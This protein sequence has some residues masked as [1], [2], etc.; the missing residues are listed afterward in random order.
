[1]SYTR[2]FFRRRRLST[3]RTVYSLPDTQESALR[4]KFV[5][6]YD[7]HNLSSGS[8]MMIRITA[9]VLLL[10]LP[11]LLAG[12]TR[13]NSQLRS[14][15][16]LHVTVIDATGA[17]PRPDTTVLII[18][19]R[20]AQIG[21]SE[22]L[23][24]PD[25]AHIVD[26]TGKFLIP[27]LW[28]MHVHFWYDDMLFPLYI[29]NG[30]TGVR[31][32]GSDL[33]RINHWRKEISLGSVSGPLIIAA[34]TPLD[35]LAQQSPLNE[36][37]VVNNAEEARRAVITLKNRGVDFIKVIS[38][39]S[40]QTY[41]AI[42]EEAKRQKI[43]FAGHLPEA[44]T[45]VEAS[46]AGQKSMEHM[47]GIALACSSEEVSL[48]QARAE[49]IKKQDWQTYGRIADQ[50]LDT[51][52]DEKAKAL[53]SRF[54]KNGTYQVPTLTLLKRMGY[55]YEG[56]PT[57]DL[58]LNYIPHSIKDGW[59]NPNEAKKNLSV[60]VQAFFKKEYQKLAEILL[61]M[62]RAG[63]LVM[64]GT[65]TAD[66]YTYPGFTLHDE[67]A[68]LVGAGL[69]PIETI[70][71]ATLIPAKYLGLS[72]SLG[73][74]EKR[75]IA[76][77]LLLDGNPLEDIRNTKKINAVVLHGRFLDRKTLDSMLS[78]AETAAIKK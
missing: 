28:D 78:E 20:I 7:N 53:F 11:A 73:T 3:I 19:D 1:L 18:G 50:L 34:G 71:A 47:F 9:S 6:I 26:A 40:H 13:Q 36:P 38:A 32:M 75:K 52:S 41:F 64:A 70:Q 49:A 27:G 72:D 16:F 48:R 77:L 61:A 31:D 29:A 76:D 4:T 30:V 12:Q 62:R 37:I 39:L 65:D 15:A 33:N 68:L 55:L 60:R 54:V 69:T 14:L 46:D 63:V 67:L 23:R 2:K 35:G 59:E 17:P 24:I 57:K 5:F 45:A 74:I 25:N 58:R 43:P 8:I 21:K 66:P 56:D 10:F 42:A 51:Y 44:I 22:T